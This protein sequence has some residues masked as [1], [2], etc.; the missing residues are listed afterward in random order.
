MSSLRDA[1]TSPAGQASRVLMVRPESFAFNE[2]TAETN[3]FQ[4]R[5]ASR[6]E[7]SVAQRARWEFEALTERL[8][9]AGVE[10]FA[11]ADLPERENPDAVFPNN[12]IS[13]HEDG[14][15][16]LYPMMAPTRRT[17][18]RS[19]IVE[20][21][22]AAGVFRGRRLLDLTSHAGE[23]RFL[24]GTG[25]LVLDRVHRVA[26]ASISPRTDPSLVELWCRELG[27]RPVVFESQ[28][29]PGAPVYHTN[30]VMSV[31][32]GLA[33]VCLE[34]IGDTGQRLAV[35]AS[36]VETGHEILAL[37]RDQMRGFAGNVL[38]LRST[39]GE[40]LV[41]ASERAR[42]ALDADQIKAIERHARLVAVPLDVIEIHGGGSVR[43]MMAEIA[44]VAI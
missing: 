37:S 31:G 3:L 35:E 1:V 30:V 12:W 18:V 14:T 22:A 32:S 17:E 6:D 10:V 33:F 9:L 36:L 5:E 26:Y 40:A 42:Q 19:D 4:R 16:V 2:E 13:F 24:E 39:A 34:S 20:S 7:P 15:I 41:F 43:C 38:E 25:S 28:D 8:R 11:F 21:L 27:Y 23:G 44:S 29:P